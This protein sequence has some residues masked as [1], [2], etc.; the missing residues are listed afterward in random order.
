MTWQ[1][2]AVLM[3]VEEEEFRDM[4]NDRLSPA[5]RAYRKGQTLSTFEISKSITRLAKLGSPQAQ[6]IIRDDISRQSIA[7]NEL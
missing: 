2:I 3:D 1:Q 5:S 7:E 6:M 4:L